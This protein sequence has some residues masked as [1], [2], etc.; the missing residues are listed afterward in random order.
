MAN[1]NQNNLE[2][3]EEELKEVSGGWF[4]EIPVGPALVMSCPS[5]GARISPM[6]AR[7][8]T[9]GIPLKHR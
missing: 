7:C 9:C 8:N 5:C 3:S 2:L 1:K 6:D 4:R